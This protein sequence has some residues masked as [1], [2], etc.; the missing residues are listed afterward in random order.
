MIELPTRVATIGAGNMA[1][2]FLS[3]LARAG[4]AADHLIAADPDPVRRKHLAETLGIRVTA[5]NTEAVR[6][7]DVAVIAV[8]PTHVEAA[9][10]GLPQK[11]APLYLSIV[12]GRTVSWLRGVLGDE[13]RIVRSM[14]NTPALIGAGITALAVDGRA[15]TDDLDRA[16]AVLAAVGRVVRVPESQLDAVTG[17]S[18]SGPA[19]VF[20]FIESLTDAG[21]RE[22]LPIEVARALAAETVLGAARLLRESG[23]DPA[24]LRKRVTSPAG[25]TAAGLA[26]LE[27]AGFRAALLGAVRSATERSRELAS[28]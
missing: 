10:T 19:Y 5:D 27:A 1:E 7:A 9:L 14:P 24:V 11:D 16:E 4:L 13:A 25:T 28:S 18:G 6:S 8:K 26:S 20:L 22:G 21:V 2:A 15:A 12:A 3:G 17:L 23:E